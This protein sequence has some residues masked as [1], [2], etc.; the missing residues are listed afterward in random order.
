MVVLD[1]VMVVEILDHDA[2]GLGDRTRRGV[3]EP[4]DPLESRA[5]AEM[6]TRHRID[7]ASGH[8]WPRQIVRAKPH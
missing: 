4:V 5:V 3:A 7:A 8:G 1:A 2:E 6:K